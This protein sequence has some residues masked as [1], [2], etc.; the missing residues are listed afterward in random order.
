[1]IVLSG[2]RSLQISNYCQR[3]WISLIENELKNTHRPTKLSRT[4]LFPALWDPTTTIC[5]NSYKKPSSTSAHASRSLFMNSTRF[6]WLIW[7]D[8]I[9]SWFIDF[10][11]NRKFREL[12]NC[13]FSWMRFVRNWFSNAKWHRKWNYIFKKE[14]NRKSNSIG[15][16]RWFDLKSCKANRNISAKI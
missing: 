7:S 14:I 6:N 5:G 12:W 8:A 11:Y 13:H 1:M 15:W 10:P 9:V 3:L 16:L 2:I 4:E